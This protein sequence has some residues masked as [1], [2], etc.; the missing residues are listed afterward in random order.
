M[1]CPK[2]HSR[3]MTDL[4]LS[5]TSLLVLASLTLNNCA[6]CFVPTFPIAPG[7]PAM[8]VLEGP[9][10]ASYMHASKLRPRSRRR[11]VCFMGNSA[12]EVKTGDLLAYD[13]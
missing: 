8:L 6:P 11:R 13:F 4:G 10:N 2:S 1:V 3:L 7:S 5:P 12:K 9:R